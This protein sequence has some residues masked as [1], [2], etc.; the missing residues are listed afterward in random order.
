MTPLL[1]GSGLTTLLIFAVVTI[2]LMSLMQRPMKKQ[3]QQQAEMRNA[4]TGGTRVLLVGGLFGTVTHVG[5]EQVIVE[6]AP[7]VEVTATKAAISR[8][9]TADDE[10]FEFADGTDD[11]YVDAPAVAPV[12]EQAPTTGATDT[13]GSTAAPAPSA[14]HSGMPAPEGTVGD[15]RPAL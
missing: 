9:V 3:A 2:L 13:T 6:L 8:T 15:D 4:I 7:G 10:E 11:E 1:A 5:N 12:A 14:E